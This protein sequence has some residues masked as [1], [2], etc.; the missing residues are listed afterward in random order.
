MQ[1]SEMHETNME[2]IIFSVNLWK[3]DCSIVIITLNETTRKTDM[4][5]CQLKFVLQNR[6]Y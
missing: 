5:R 1:V 4:N 3:P 6:C 2:L